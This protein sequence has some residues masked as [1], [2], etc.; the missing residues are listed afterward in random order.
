MRVK[1]IG[2]FFRSMTFGVIL[3]AAIALLSVAGSL[4]PQNQETMYYVRTYSFY[5][6]ILA[7]SLND[8]FHTWYFYLLCALLCVNLLLCSILRFHRVRTSRVVETAALSAEEVI[9]PEAGV[10]TVKKALEREHCKK[11]ERDSPSGK[12]SVYTK[13]LFGRYGS[14]ITHIGILLCVIFFALALEMPKVTDE[15]VYPGRSL[16][17]DDGTEIFVK[18]FHIEDPEGNLDYRSTIEIVLPDGRS[19][20]DVET[21]VNHPASLGSIKVYQQTY[22]TAGQITVTDT[23]G[24]SDS[25]IMEDRMFISKDQKTGIWYNTLY[26]DFEQGAEGS[27]SLGTSTSG[28]YRNPVYTFNLVESSGQERGKMLD[29]SVSLSQTET[30]AESEAEDELTMTPMLA[31]PGD[32]ITVGDLTFHF[33]EP[34]EYP[35]LRIKESPGFINILLL[36][37]FL[38]LTFGLAVIFLCQPVIVTVTERGYRVLGP[39]KEGTSLMLKRVLRKAGIRQLNTENAED[40]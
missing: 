27:F 25:F 3:L 10:E 19:S 35:G 15:A 36:T 28:A 39:K 1:K 34:L 20:G 32:Q 40:R 5:R 9:L 38:I 29:G 31:F 33:D 21:S 30:E 23:E 12:R 6:L 37:A 26:P 4:I 11:A 17:M 16:R 13:N 24:N 8:V 22:G 7:L 18:D 14:L 2:R